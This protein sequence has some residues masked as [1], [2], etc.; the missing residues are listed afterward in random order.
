MRLLFVNPNVT[1]AITDIMVAEARRSAST[2]TTIVP[3][4]GRF[5][6]LFVE[7]GVEAAIAGHAV[8]DAVA[9]HAEG[10]DAVVVSAF[11]DPGLRAAKE[12]LDIPVVGVSEAAFLTAYT[13]GRT[14]AIVCLTKRH[15]AWYVECAQE[16]GLHG[17]MVSARALTVPVPDIT[18]AR[19]QMKDLL[20]EQCLA[21]VEED[22]AEVII[23]GGGP[24]AGLAREIR[25]RIPVPTI[26]GISCG[27]RLAEMLVALNPRPPVR[28]SFARPPAKPAKG[29]SP[30][31]M[32]RLSGRD[33]P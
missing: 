24:M 13:L 29:L 27:V 7:N 33:Q 25:D 5:G 26:D 16:H 1:E 2:T 12:L 14:Y 9:E 11:G 22:D 28:G 3:A 10:C 6:T 19:E 15:R 30:S 18:R 21:A 4:T 20:I 32:R 31:L 23:L 8:I 17:R